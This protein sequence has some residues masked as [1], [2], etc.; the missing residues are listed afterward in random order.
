MSVFFPVPCAVLLV[1]AVL[2]AVGGSLGGST[3]LS[4][5]SCGAAVFLFINATS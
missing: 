3:R 4:P 2:G 1:T 5:C